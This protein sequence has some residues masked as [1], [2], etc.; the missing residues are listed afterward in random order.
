MRWVVERWPCLV[1]YR[2]HITIDRCHGGPRSPTRGRTGPS[3]ELHHTRSRKALQPC[4][5][6]KGGEPVLRGSRAPHVRQVLR[7]TC[8]V[9]NGRYH[10][11]RPS[12]QT[13]N[14]STDP[15]HPLNIRLLYTPSD[16]PTHRPIPP[17]TI[18]LQP[19]AHPAHDRRCGSR[20]I[21]SLC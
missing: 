7:D 1:S 4:M 5:Q 2:S 14:T 11:S 9:G 21:L 17:Q 20:P 3:Q 19:H 15:A 10:Y 6:C 13:L 16:P 18:A 8:R 12:K